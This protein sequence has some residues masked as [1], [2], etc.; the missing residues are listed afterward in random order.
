MFQTPRTKQFNVQKFFYQEFK[1]RDLFRS[2][3][4]QCCARGWTQLIS[5]LYTDQCNVR[6][7]LKIK[8]KKN[9]RSECLWT[10][11]TEFQQELR[12]VWKVKR[13]Q[14]TKKKMRKT[15]TLL[16]FTWTTAQVFG[17]NWHNQIKVK[18]GNETRPLMYVKIQNA[19]LSERQTWQQTFLFFFLGICFGTQ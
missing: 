15:M 13:A 8:I 2:C 19:L 14:E 6:E 4:P 1:S 7:K 12:Q 5:H 10:W 11:A 18:E 16:T 17:H 3:H 9:I